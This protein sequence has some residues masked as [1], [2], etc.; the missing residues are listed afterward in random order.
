[1]KI[2]TIE[3]TNINDGHELANWVYNEVKD[4]DYINVDEF[5]ASDWLVKACNALK[6]QSIP[7]VGGLIAEFE[8]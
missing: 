2:F 6:W 7:S 8:E 1:M 5:D 3:S 4:I